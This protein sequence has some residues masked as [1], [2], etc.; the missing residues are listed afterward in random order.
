VSDMKKT[1]GPARIA[2]PSEVP[3]DEFE[4]NV[5]MAAVEE[6]AKPKVRGIR[7]AAIRAEELRRKMEEGGG[8]GDTHDDFYVD[9]RKIPDGW[10]YNWKRHTVANMPD[11][12]YETELLQ[13]GWEPVD[14]SRHPDMVPPGYKGPIVRKGMILMERPKEISDMA[15]EKESRNARELVYN[16]ERELGIAP[17]GTFE[18]DGRTGVK[19]SYGPMEVPRA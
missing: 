17:K 12:A 13:A 8:N 2:R 11:P 18:R 14:A 1:R 16:K 4:T 3:D 15:K 5:E 9:P 6:T 19:K 7:E 10:D